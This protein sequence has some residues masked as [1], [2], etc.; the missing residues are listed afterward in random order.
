M[1]EKAQRLSANRAVARALLSGKLKREA[2]EICG[3]WD[4]VVAHHDNYQKPLAV[5]WLCHRHHMQVHSPRGINPKPNNKGM[6]AMSVTEL[7]RM[8]GHAKAKKFKQ[9][10]RNEQQT[11]QKVEGHNKQ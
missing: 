4:I 8:G 2:C 1:K 9:A 7:A 10:G 3:S 5:R 6:G 11:N